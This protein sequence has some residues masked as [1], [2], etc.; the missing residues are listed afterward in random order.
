MSG[1][2]PADKADRR[3]TNKPARGEWVEIERPKK[4][5]LPTLMQIEKGDW[6]PRTKALWESWRKDAATTM[7]EPADEQLAVETIYLHDERVNG[8]PVTLEAEIRIRM[9]MLG[10]TAKGRQDRRWRVVDEVE[11]APAA[12]GDD[13]VGA[14]RARREAQLAANG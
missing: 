10:L 12:K 14:R 2:A 6:H 13:E 1:P 4:A 5:L 11:E 3:R 8:G 9:D 7:W